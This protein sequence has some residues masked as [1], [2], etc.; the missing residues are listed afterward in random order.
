M[1]RTLALLSLCAG[2]LL[3]QQQKSDLVAF[4]A[5]MQPSNEVPA[6]SDT[7]SG[8]AI[9][10]AHVVN[11]GTNVL[12]A[13]VDFNITT[14]FSSAVTVTGLHIHS[15]AAG[16]AGG[17]VIPTD[18]NGGANSIAID[19]TGKASIAKQVQS[20]AGNAM[21]AVIL[22]MINN[23]QNYYVNIHTTDHG[24]GAMRGQLYKAD[25]N[26]L[27]GLMSPKNEV[28]PTPVTASG[29]ASVL[30]LRGKDA[31][32]KTA[33]AT[34]IFDM[35]YTGFD[36][37]TT[38][39]G[40][41]IHDGVAGVNGGVIINTG[42]SGSNT[43]VVDASGAGHINIPVAMTPLDASFA[44]EMRT[45]D[46]L[47]VNPA[48]HYINIHTTTFGG[49]VMRDQMRLTETAVI[50]ANMQPSNETPPIAGLTA[51][52]AAQV[53]I[54]LL[55][56][57]DG[58]IAAGTVL[59]D[60]NFRGF[61][62]ST[63]FT[64]LHIHNAAAGVAGPVLISSGLDANANKVVSD[65][66]S[67]NVMRVITV[68]DT[69]GI[70]A[71]NNL[72]KDPSN[73]Y[74]NMHTTVNPGGAIRD[75]LA[76]PLA[77]PVING[78]AAA[79]SPVLTAAPGAII[80][81][82]G[83]NLAGFTS[84]LNG[85]APNSALATSMNGV[86]VTV[87]GKNAPFYYVSPAQLNVQ[88]P[89]E[90]ANGSQPVV[91]TT[92]AGASSATNLTVAATAPSIVVVGANNLGAVTKTDFSLVSSSNT[93]K[94]GDVVIVFSTGL[95]QTTAPLTTGA[96]TAP[97]AGT[98]NNT[99]TVTATIGGKDASVAYSIAA[100]GFV[101]LYQTAITV[102]AGATGSQQLV[103]TTGGVASNAVNLAI[104]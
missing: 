94:A 70:G 25:I 85:F 55:R 67:G 32:G 88:V 26:V 41:H 82:Y 3:A 43:L 39:T 101:G 33:M 104:Q 56:N 50:Q 64:G 68:A 96:I 45:S 23:P 36:P 77:K 90:V 35:L 22:D 92:A 40:F 69:A 100:P 97:P 58:S 84:A 102:P 81:L 19:A 17:I 7:S 27:M 103:L 73:F 99:G 12:S 74:I 79:S 49:G 14:K 16:V 54:A 8:T 61:P 62:A 11:D 44:A 10:W 29:I 18:V 31:S 30:L 75:Q 24:G 13:S 89:F 6:I 93:V 98:F 80:S 37:G 57:A 52:G 48:A 21:N 2:S 78:I 59:F 60:V 53:P 87:G 28:P 86:T 65:T 72:V 47:T 51:S 15:G 66:G 4:L 91:V 20:P 1:K 83:T 42:L 46:D 71:L 76:S 5:L 95:G 63:T 34:A 38:F 9:I